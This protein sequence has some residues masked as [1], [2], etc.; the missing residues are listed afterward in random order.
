[1]RAVFQGR[2]VLA[3]FFRQGFWP[4]LLVAENVQRV[5]GREHFARF[6]MHDFVAEFHGAPLRRQNLGAHHQQIVKTRGPL[7]TAV[8]IGDHD[9][10][11]ILAFH[12]FIFKS[13]LAAQIHAAHFE[14]GEI[15][16]VVHHSHLVRFGVAHTNCSFAVFHNCLGNCS[17][18]QKV[19]PACEAD[20]R[21]RRTHCPVHLGWRFSRNEA[22]PSRKSS[23]ARMSAFSLVA[24]SISC[25]IS[26]SSYSSSRRLVRR[27]LV[28]LDS[29]NFAATSCALFS[30]SSAGTISV[31]I[32][33]RNASAASII[34]PV[35]SNSRACFSPIC[36]RSST[37]TS[38]GINPMRTSV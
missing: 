20:S 3:V 26:F 8:R 9:V 22:S 19:A 23:V 5:S 6:L 2:E 7:E 25:A 29:R 14:P 35:S 36:L 31:T 32:P 27:R 37:E 28:G 11:V 30:K 38:A 34:A 33:S 15:I 18:R 21:R 10:T 13:Q 24:I 17:G 4:P 12:F 1:M 16:A